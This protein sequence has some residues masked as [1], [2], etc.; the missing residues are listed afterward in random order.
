MKTNL[1]IQM[2]VLGHWLATIVVLI[3]IG[4]FL[5][6]FFRAHEAFTDAFESAVSIAGKLLGLV[7]TAE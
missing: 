1:I 7:V 3:A 6:A 5:L 4:A 2:E